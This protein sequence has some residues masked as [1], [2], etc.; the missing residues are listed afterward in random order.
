MFWAAHAELHLLAGLEVVQLQLQLVPVSLPTGR[1]LTGLT[2]QLLQDVILNG[3]TSVIPGWLPLDLT[4][5]LVNSTHLQRSLRGAGRAED[6]KLHL[7]LVLP[8]LVDGT[9]HVEAGH[10]PGGVPDLNAGEEL[11]VGDGAVLLLS[12]VP[13]L[14]VPGDLRSWTSINW[15][16]LKLKSLPSPRPQLVFV[17]VI[18]V[19]DWRD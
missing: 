18:S 12:A 8:V 19:D 5:L 13:G 17:Q 4:A 3:A 1:P 16:V 2:V 11:G 14:E 6:H 10:L 9:D 7:G 15:L